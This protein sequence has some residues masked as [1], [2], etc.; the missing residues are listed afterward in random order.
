M[1]KQLI[2]P[3]FCMMLLFVISYLVLIKTRVKFLKEKKV[4]MLYFKNYVRTADMPDEF[5]TP[6]RMLNNLYEAPI[7]YFVVCSLAI[8][9]KF[10]TLLFLTLSWGF[11]IFR[12]LHAIVLLKSG[13]VKL[14][15]QVFLSSMVSLVGLWILLLLGAINS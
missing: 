4:K 10:V 7:L 15:F 14:R 6:S 11:V 9:L 3:L 5:F 2:Y 8:S 12:V 13:S 1:E